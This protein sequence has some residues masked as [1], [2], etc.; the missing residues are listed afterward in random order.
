MP[1]GLWGSKE[2]TCANEELSAILDFVRRRWTFGMAVDS[3]A[4]KE[5]WWKLELYISLHFFMFPGCKQTEP[6]SSF[7][8]PSFEQV[9][10][11]FLGE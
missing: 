8:I 3:Q 11:S 1:N 9:P 4:G 5:S 2:S 6:L 10:F 7:V